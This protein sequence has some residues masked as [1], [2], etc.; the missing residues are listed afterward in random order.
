M[1]RARI[2]AVITKNDRELVARVDKFVDFYELRIDL[3]GDGWQELA[4]YLKHP[5]IACNRLPAEGGSWTGDEASRIAKLFE[6]IKLGAEIIDIELKTPELQRIVTGIKD[7]RVR[8]LIS[9]HD[10]K[11]TPTLVDIRNIIRQEY[12]AGADICKLVTTAQHFEDNLT[13]LKIFEYFKDIRIV[14]FAMGPLGLAS[15]VLSPMIGGYF[16]YASIVE[17]RESAS[18]QLTAAYLRSLYESV[19]NNNDG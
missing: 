8:C 2:C 19:K 7:R 12:D 6:A 9:H 4:G 10:Y 18:G 5:W 17:G 3:V 14:A 15:R 16:T 13:L 11:E 1:I